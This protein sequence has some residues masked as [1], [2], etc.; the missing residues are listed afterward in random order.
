MATSAQINSLT[1][2][3]VGYFDRAPDPAGL[4]AWINAIDAGIGIKTIAGNFA[5][6][7]E[8]KDLYPYLET[9]GLV[10]PATFVGSIYVN[11]FNR[12]AETA[13]LDFWVA[14][15]E[16]GAI[17]PEEMILEI[18][19]GAQ[20]SDQTILNNKI[21]A[22][23]FFAETAA[24]ASG[25][26]YD[27]ADAKSAIDGVTAD[28][29]TVTA[30]K[31]ATEA[32]VSDSVNVGTTFTLTTGLDD[33]TGT[34]NADTIKG[35]QS[36]TA[37]EETFSTT[38]DIDGGAGVDTLELTSLEG[39]AVN[40]ATVVN[41]ENMIY[42]ATVAGGDLDLANFT[43]ITNLTLDR[44]VGA[45]DFSG[46]AT[47]DSL[48]FLNSTANMDTTV[49]YAGVAGTAD[50]ATVTLKGV[51][52][53]ADIQ[54]AGAVE[55]MTLK[56]S[57]SA[58]T[59][60]D[61][62]FDAGTTA[63]N[64]EADEA[65]TVDTTFMGGGIAKITATGD[66][67]VTITPTLGTATKEVD[68]SGSTGGVSVVAGNVADDGTTAA[69]FTFKGGAGKDAVD[70]TA[71]DDADE[72][73]LVMGGGDDTVTIGGD[74]MDG[75]NDN[76]DGGDGT[77]TLVVNNDAAITSTTVKSIKNFETLS[78]TDDDGGSA[79]TFDVSLLSGITSIKVAATSAG[80]AITLNNLSAA[81]AG[82]ITVSGT[83]AEDLTL[84]VKDAGTVG[85]L[86]TVGLT[87]DDGLAATNTITLA[88]LSATGVETV[89]ITANDNATFTLLTGL[90]GLTKLDVGGAGNVS[91]TTGA[92]A[93]NVNTVIDASDVTG[94]VT[95]DASA[96]TANGASI[97]GSATK[98]NTITGTN[99]DDVIT[100][101]TGVDTVTNTN[102]AATD[103]DTLDFVS[104]T[105]A[106]I[107]EVSSVLGKTTITNFD[108]ATTTTTEDLVNVSN[109][110]VDGAEDVITAAAAQGALGNDKTVIIEQAVGAAGALTTGGTATLDTA[111]FTA[112]TLTDV[113][114]YLSER[115]TDVNTDGEAALFILNNGT[116]SYM[117]AFNDTATANTTIDADEIS[118]IGVV[119][120]ALLSAED[121]FQTV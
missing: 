58:S 93:L 82:A 103:A 62:V 48:T 12:P 13:G 29:A 25:Y 14:A 57:G 15:L 85:Q 116:N 83:Q 115:F 10:T 118:L 114:A 5:D 21:E 4:Q 99:Q 64:I 97:K 74:A 105:A 79:E 35:V 16:S 51:A 71:T 50:A 2:L 81:Q 119:N 20:G 28:T 22:G 104:D 8:A 43:S 19:G 63:L 77:D 39:A 60:D 9:P 11:L 80:D 90:T 40:A 34:A 6:S 87:V 120:N 26:D 78:V 121:V 44:T 86:D 18:I 92:L 73:S 106:D 107:F 68:A 117:Y 84:G 91:L 76:V 96:A 52:D 66:S 31:A 37:A 23:R 27:I 33:I 101:G 89:N 41:V 108:A 42:R 69:D 36:A 59:L 45:T 32:A 49:T 46:L 47:S 95:V 102:N 88:D 98:A 1:S 67:L 110:T 7:A 38:D 61:L 70:I 94:T 113:A 17:S 112:A 24:S 54:F 65:L 109:D 53:G 55:T 3:Y 100:G 56:T 30:A 75:T 72:L 111:D